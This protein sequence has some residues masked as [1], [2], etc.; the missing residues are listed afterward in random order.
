MHTGCLIHPVKQCWLHNLLLLGLMDSV[1]DHLQGNL[2]GILVGRENL[3]DGILYA[4]KETHYSV[5]KAACM[6][7][8]DTI[9]VCAL[10]PYSNRYFADVPLAS[11]WTICS[12]VE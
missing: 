10:E 8:M 4:S 12:S 5:F 9:K 11:C 7:R 6:Y 3:P 2:H 1:Y